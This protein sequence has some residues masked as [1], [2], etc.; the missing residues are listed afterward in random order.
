MDRDYEG[1]IPADAR[2]PLR[3]SIVAPHRGQTV[4]VLGILSLFVAPV[5]LGP[6]AWIMGRNDLKEMDAG[7]MDRA[8]RDN[9]KAGV[10]CGM[11][12][13]L[14][15]G[16]VT[17]SFLLLFCVCLGLPTMLS[18]VAPP[19]PAP[20]VTNQFPA[21][22][23]QVLGTSREQPVPTQR[24]IPGGQHGMDPIRCP[25]CATNLEYPEEYDMDSYFRCANCRRVFKGE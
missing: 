10:I 13:T 5:I 17:V 8:G 7:R 22:P 12:S 19:R 1:Y 9:T 21:A 14:L 4:M 6:M 2:R 3:G 16:T 18:A 11:V 23:G 25:H 24:A 15:W 20:P